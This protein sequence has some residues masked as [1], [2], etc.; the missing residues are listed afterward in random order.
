MAQVYELN[1]LI[2]KALAA[3]VLVEKLSQFEHNEVSDASIVQALADKDST[4]ALPGILS[5]CIPAGRIPAFMSV[6]KRDETW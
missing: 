3:L 1:D 5:L 4:A 6:M 2:K